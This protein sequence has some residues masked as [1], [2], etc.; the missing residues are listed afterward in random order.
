V[1]DEDLRREMGD[2][3]CSLVREAGYTNA[4][5]VEFI[6]DP[7]GRFY[8]LEM[9][10]RLQVEHP[11]TEM[12]TSLDLVELQILVS[13][14]KP[15]PVGQQD[16]AIRGWAVEARVCA[17]DTERGFFPST[18]IITRYAEPRGKNIRLDSGIEAGAF[19]SVF[20][21]SLLA[22]LVACGE[23]RSEAINTLSHALN[24]YHIEGVTT[25]IDFCNAIVNHPVFKQGDIS[26]GFIEEHFRDGRP[27]TEPPVEMIHRMIMA[28]TLVYHNRQ[29]LVR[30]SLKPMTAKVGQVQEQDVWHHYVV[31]KDEDV[32]TV[33]LLRDV[34][35]QNWIITVNDH[36]YEV[37]APDFEFYRRRLKLEIEGLSEYFRLQ[38]RENFIWAAFCGA[39]A[40]LEIYSPK[41]WGLAPYMPKLK[42]VEEEKNLLSPMPGLVVDIRV[43]QGD[44]VYRGQDLVV[45]ESMKM[46]SGVSS[47]RDGEVEEIKI[48]TGTAVEAG[49]TLIT[50]KPL[51][52]S[53]QSKP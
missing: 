8:F 26:T 38:Y 37:K 24:R 22:K 2:K 40:T 14:D 12:V 39:T 35:R 9:N 23:T 27:K 1:V 28:A 32:F 17:E 16:V 47:P 52:S 5:T 21:D 51:G 29:N 13:A 18:G 46:Q 48:T 10:T 43:K 49:D 33:R 11:V 44:R 4:G 25:N 3:A 19:V 36:R 7:N 15:L 42:A 41:E 6:L 31:K 50:F 20:Y 34:V 53:A 45:I 30:D